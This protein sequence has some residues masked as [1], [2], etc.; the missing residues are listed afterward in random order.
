MDKKIL[1]NQLIR[2]RKSLDFNVKKSWEEKIH[3]QI[4]DLLAPY[5][6]I[7][8]YLSMDFEIDTMRLIRQLPDKV[9]LAPRIDGDLMHFHHLGKQGSQHRFGMWEPRA[10]QIMIP[11]VLIIPMIG[12]NESKYRIGFGKGYYDRYLKDFTGTSI[13]MAFQQDFVKFKEQ[14]WDKQLDLIITEEGYL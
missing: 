10:G 14:S 4:L 6:Q 1:R 8:L 9:L 11:E 5:Q 12:F 7:G 3:Q 13:G 2:Q